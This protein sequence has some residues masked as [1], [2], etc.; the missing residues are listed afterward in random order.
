MSSP[1]WLGLLKWTLANSDG[2]AVSTASQMNEED[3]LWLERVLKEGVK[4]EPA[5]MNEIMVSVYS[6]LDGT[7]VPNDD[8]SIEDKLLND[9]EELQD[10][11]EQIDMAQILSKCGGIRAMIAL[12]EST[13]E[14]VSNNVKSQAISVIGTVVQNNIKVQDE[15][16]SAGILSILVRLFNT[17]ESSLV[18]NKI[19]YAISCLIRNHAAAEESFSLQYAST[20][21]PKA[22]ESDRDSLIS[23]AIFLCN[24]LITSDYCTERRI[25]SLVSTVLPVVLAKRG[26]P[27]STSTDCLENTIHLL[28]TVLGSEFGYFQCTGAFRSNLNAMIDYLRSLDFLRDNHELLLLTSVLQQPATILYPRSASNSSTSPV[29]EENSGEVLMIGPPLLPAGAQ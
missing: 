23:R 28:L 25:A 26:G 9:L 15:N 22:L 2:T 24:A 21:L 17:A 5:R 7:F 14:V 29:L 4:D 13:L 20:V 18:C 16:F 3:K 8:E 27:Y 1:Q 12:A 11:T 10:I 6:I 19:L